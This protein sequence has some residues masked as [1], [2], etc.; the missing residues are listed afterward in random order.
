LWLGN[1]VVGATVVINGPNNFQ[2]SMLTDSDG[3][4]SFY[5]LPDG[6]YHVALLGL[7]SS[8]PSYDLAVGREIYWGRTSFAVTF[9]AAR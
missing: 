3:S 6:N 9:G 5:N 8:P 4:Y 2:S 7:P 1:A